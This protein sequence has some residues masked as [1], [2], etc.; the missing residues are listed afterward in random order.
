MRKFTKEIT[1]LIASAAIGTAVGVGAFSA[2]SEEIVQTAGEQMIPDETICPTEIMVTDPTEIPPLGG[3][4]LP[5]DELTE[6]TEIPPLIGEPLPSDELIEPTDPTIPP[7]VGD[8]LPSDELIEPTTEE[9]P[10]LAGDIMPADGDVNGDGLFSV[11]DIVLFRKWLLN[12]PDSYF[13]NWWAADFNYDGK[14]NV[15]DLTLMKK[16]LLNNNM[17]EN[18]ND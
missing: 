15:Y 11:A 13:S 10:P 2:S 7:M 5:P 3:V 1:A 17:P 9:I 18:D 6:P 8:P 16:A 4:P 12:I 14:L